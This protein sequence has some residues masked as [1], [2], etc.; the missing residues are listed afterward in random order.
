[1]HAEI[2]RVSILSSEQKCTNI[3]TEQTLLQQK[4]RKE[5]EVLVTPK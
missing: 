4:Y 1:M 5:I 2:C 3:L